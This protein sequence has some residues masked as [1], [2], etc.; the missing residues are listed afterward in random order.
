MHSHN[1][2]GSEHNFSVDSSDLRDSFSYTTVREWNKLPIEV[3]KKK[4]FLLQQTTGWIWTESTV[5][6]PYYNKQFE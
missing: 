2:R 3:K 4:G 5:P 6:T 1:T